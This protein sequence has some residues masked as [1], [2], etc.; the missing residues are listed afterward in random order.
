MGFYSARYPGDIY[1]WFKPLAE[2]EGVP[3]LD[4]H[5][6]MSSLARSDLGRYA[7]KR[8]G[9]PTEEALGLVAEKVWRWLGPRLRTD[10]G[11]R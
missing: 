6:L 11:R 5:E 2:A 3:F 8:D 7:I 10:L 4:L 1:G 9:H